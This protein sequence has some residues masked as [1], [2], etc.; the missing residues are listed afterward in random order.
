MNHSKAPPNVAVADK[1]ATNKQQIKYTY[2]K[3]I[4]LTKILTNLKILHEAFFLLNDLGS[5]PTEGASYF[6]NLVSKLFS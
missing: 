5:V 1:I 6:V 2:S 3:K 4:L